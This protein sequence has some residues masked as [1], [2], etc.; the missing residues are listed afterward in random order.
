M[1]PFKLLG[2]LKDI[3]K[4]QQDMKESARKLKE[5]VYEGAAGGGLVTV[6]ATG[7]L[8]LTSVAVDPSLVADKDLDLIQELIVEAA[9]IALTKAR[10]DAATTMQK[11]LQE[12]LDIPGLDGLVKGMM[13]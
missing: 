10:D 3:G 11:T 6:K 12:R 13:P 4:I 5:N 1:N 2:A 9:N 8:Q 7:D